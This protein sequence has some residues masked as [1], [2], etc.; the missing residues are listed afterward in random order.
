MGAQYN[1]NYYQG[2]YEN[3]P[4]S[5]KKGSWTFFTYQTFK[6]DKRSQISL[7]GFMRL[8]GQ[9]QF[10]ELST[11]GALNT[12]INREFFKQKLTVTMSLNDIFYSNKNEFTISQGSV[13]ASGHRFADTRRFGL[14]IRY[15]FGIRKKEDKNDILN[16]D[17]PER[18]N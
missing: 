4:L 17:S 6:I 10:Y 18:T 13:S 2:L 8:K 15:N 5:Y 3:K 14:N 12:S 1:H 16:I 7:N 11:F 9:L